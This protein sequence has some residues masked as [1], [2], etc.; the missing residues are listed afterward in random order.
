MNAEL[1]RIAQEIL[2]ITTLE[3]R[4]LD[5]L[6]FHELSVWRLKKALEAAYLAGQRDVKRDS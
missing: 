3:T 5:L 6:D 2:G 1:E 4:D